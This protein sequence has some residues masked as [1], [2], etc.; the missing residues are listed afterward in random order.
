MVIHPVFMHPRR[1]VTSPMISCT[2]F[3]QSIFIEMVFYFAG[4]YY[5]YNTEKN[6]TYETTILDV[7]AMIDKEKMPFR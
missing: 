6:R 1:G 5:Y 4:A 7:K 2:S 3:S